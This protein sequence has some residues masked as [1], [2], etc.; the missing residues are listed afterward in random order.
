M[1]NKKYYLIPIFDKCIFIKDSDS[2]YISLYWY[3]KKYY[4]KLTKLEEERIGVLYSGNC[5]RPLTSL[6]KSK[7]S[8]IQSKQKQ[9]S[10]EL[11][12]PL[13]ILAVGNNK[14]VYEL[15]TKEPIISKMSGD[16]SIREVSRDVFEKKYDTSYDSRIQKFINRKNFMLIKSDNQ[17]VLR[18]N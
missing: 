9:K 3:T 14:K 11:G 18:K 2:N 12:I 5:N 6:Q 10:D 13:F 15:I 17:K 7:I 8:M 16:I 1:F 4:S